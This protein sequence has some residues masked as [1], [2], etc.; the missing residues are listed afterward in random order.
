MVAECQNFVPFLCRCE[1]G[2]ACLFVS[3]NTISHRIERFSRHSLHLAD[4]T[5]L[6]GAD[7]ELPPERSSKDSLTRELT[8]QLKAAVLRPSTGISINGATSFEPLN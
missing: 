2:G 5:Q 8:N 7:I 6:L 4:L 3:S 1:D